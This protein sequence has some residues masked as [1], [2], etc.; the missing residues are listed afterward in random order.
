MNATRKNS[1]CGTNKM[2][3]NYLACIGLTPQARVVVFVI[4]S[5]NKT[6]FTQKRSYFKIVEIVQVSRP[7]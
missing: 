3:G 2:K 4:S 6:G 1:T 7:Q 5:K